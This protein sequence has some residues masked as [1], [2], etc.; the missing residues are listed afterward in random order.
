MHRKLHGLLRWC[1]FEYNSHLW[2]PILKLYWIWLNNPRASVKCIFGSFP[3]LFG[4]S[5]LL[6]SWLWS[7]FHCCGMIMDPWVDTLMTGALAHM[8]S[9]FLHWPFPYSLLQAL[10]ECLFINLEKWHEKYRFHVKTDSTEVLKIDCGNTSLFMNIFRGNR[11]YQF[12]TYHFIL[13]CHIIC[14]YVYDKVYNIYE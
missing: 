3:P 2:I 9:F 1:R 7:C 12:L 10:I 6:H 4:S 14:I 13:F 11:C 5:P 8:L